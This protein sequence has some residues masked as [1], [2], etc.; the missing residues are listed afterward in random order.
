MAGIWGQEIIERVRQSNDIVEVVQSLY[1]PLKRVGS[2]FKALSP[3]KKEKTPSFVVTPSKQIWYCFSTNQGGDV[4]KFVML[5]EQVDFPSAV[6]RLAKRAG[7][8]L[9]ENGNFSG[10]ASPVEQSLKQA[11]YDVHEHVAKWWHQQ[12][13]KS[14]S[15]DPAR[16]YLSVR[17]ITMETAREFR[18]GYAPDSWAATL[19]WAAEAGFSDEV[20]ERAGLARRKEETGRCYDFFRGRLMFPIHDSGGR[21][22]AFSGRLLDPEAREGKY[23]NSPETSLFSKSKILFGLDKNR[24]SLV[25]A[26]QAIVCEGPVDLITCYQ[27]GVRNMVASQGTAFT[28][29]HARILKN[30]VVDEVIL[31]FDSDSAGQGAV[32]KSVPALMKASLPVRV[33]ELPDKQDGGKYDPDSF[34]KELGADAFLAF[35]HEAPDF[36]E[37]FLRKLCEQN[38]PNND[39][40]RMVIKREV[41][42]LL[43]HVADSTK[44]DDVL[45]RLSA[46]IGASF[47][48]IKG[49]FQREI[50]RAPAVRETAVDLREHDHEQEAIA[51]ATLPPP[52]PAMTEILRIGFQ[53]PSLM[54]EIQ[55]RLDLQWAAT[56]DGRAL[57]ERLFDQ[58]SNDAWD[59]VESF[60]GELGA[61]EQAQ[62]AAVLTMPPLNGELLEEH[63]A[64]CLFKL[65]KTWLE[66]QVRRMELEIKKRPSDSSVLFSELLAWR[67]KLDNL[68]PPQ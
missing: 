24:R 10:A 7:I 67:K 52:H 42:A 44:K 6:R 54:P 19:S 5:Y 58:H 66:Q 16:K 43:P 9:P 48:V 11:L 28:E 57:V 60:V 12:L 56:L 62:A 59:G 22:V 3:F 61:A 32:L 65:E 27:A 37:Y 51:T 38:D 29:H 18:L 64:A 40:G 21:V 20:M 50:S 53:N 33:M 34:V 23:I 46:R 45:M 15:A 47:Q 8:E 41:F 30:Q 49:E 1:G 63:L 31:C 36:W 25:Q 35:S 55:K 39:R 2:N 26:R 4:F 13:M 17:G 68:L 14:P